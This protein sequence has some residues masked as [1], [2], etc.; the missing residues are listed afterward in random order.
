MALK[1][2]SRG[3]ILETGKLALQGN[4]EDLIDNEEVK[5]CYLGG[6]QARG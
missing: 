5:R 2:A 4:C 6:G 1:L 3:Y